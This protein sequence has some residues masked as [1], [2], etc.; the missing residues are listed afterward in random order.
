[1]RARPLPVCPAGEA[2]VAE[3]WGKGMKIEQQMIQCLI[4]PL[5]PLR[6]GVLSAMC[7]SLA[8]SGG[9]KALTAE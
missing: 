1:M 9:G 5:H 3:G 4:L 2:A 7:Q 6:L 8:A